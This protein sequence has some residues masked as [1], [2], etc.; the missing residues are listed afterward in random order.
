MHQIWIG[1]N[2]PTAFKR[3]ADHFIKLHP[4][5]EYKLWTEDNLPKDLVNQE[6]ID[7]CF[8]RSTMLSVISDCYRYE[9]LARYGGVY[10]DCDVLFFKNINDLIEDKSEV[11]MDENSLTVTNCFIA[12]EQNHPV[13][14]GLING[15]R[16]QYYGYRDTDSIL[17][18]AGIFYY[19]EFIR[20]WPDDLYILPR[21]TFIPFCQYHPW[22]EYWESVKHKFPMDHWYGFHYWGHLGNTGIGH[23]INVTLDMIEGKIGPD[24]IEFD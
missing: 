8:N 15:L 21:E 23:K 19:S 22:D 12:C 5:W 17:V 13:M 18:A 11:F 4:D 24:E 9:L 16:N 2:M 3:A 10:A 6:V 7:E 14:H 1:P 20:D